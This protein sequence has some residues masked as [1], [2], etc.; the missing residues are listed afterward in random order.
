M[1]SGY[2]CNCSLWFLVQQV[3]HM[4]KLTSIGRLHVLGGGG[5]GGVRTLPFV[6]F[7]GGSPV[8]AAAVVVKCSNLSE[9][10]VITEGNSISSCANVSTLSHQTNF[11]LETLQ[12]K[13]HVLVV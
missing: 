13:K 1:A 6:I 9:H 8:Y 7:F 5:E 10:Y 12:G 11:S 3:I 4:Q 2:V